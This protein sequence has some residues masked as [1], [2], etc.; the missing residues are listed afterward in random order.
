MQKVFITVLFMLPALA[1]A[2]PWCLHLDE[3]I[4]C[5]Y[6]TA[7]NCYNVASKS[8]GSCRPNS[9]ERGMRGNGTY[10]L[11]TA[12]FR[13]CTYYSLRACSRQLE[14]R[15]PGTAGCVENTEKALEYAGDRKKSFSELLRVE[16]FE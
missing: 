4:I 10:C 13:Y 1:Q 15:E 2:A 12:D 9:V 8:G 5:N 7:E 14:K 6:N 11:V 3:K 16:G